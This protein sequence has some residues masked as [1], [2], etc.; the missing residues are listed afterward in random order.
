MIDRTSRQKISKYIE[1]L[2]IIIYQLDQTDL[3]NS[4]ANN[5]RIHI[6]FKCAQNIYQ[7]RPY[8]GS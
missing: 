8:S 2:D 1:D 5:S 6:L 3:W 4:P 7:D